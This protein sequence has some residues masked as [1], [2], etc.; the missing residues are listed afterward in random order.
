[1]PEN[2]CSCQ[3]GATIE[4]IGKYLL[5]SGPPMLRFNIKHISDV[6][7]LIFRYESNESIFKSLGGH[8]HGVGG[9]VD[10]GQ[11]AVHDVGG[12][13]VQKAICI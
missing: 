10:E 4:A 12:G 1:M 3:W 8:L 13:V 6:L 7:S 11:E 5:I 9:Q 2:F